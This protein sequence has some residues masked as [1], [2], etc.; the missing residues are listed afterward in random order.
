VGVRVV[1]MG[2][3]ARMVSCIWVSWVTYSGRSRW[4]N[5]LCAFVVTWGVAYMMIVIH[6]PYPYP[7]NIIMHPIVLLRVKKS[8][9]KH[10]NVQMKFR[11]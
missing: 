2:K 5:R 3:S 6:R 11:I 8:M 7:A 4:I 1:S 10:R 9:E